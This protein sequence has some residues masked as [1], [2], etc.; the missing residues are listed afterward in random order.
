MSEDI[1]KLRQDYRGIRAPEHLATRIRAEVADQV[2]PRRS[3]LP[4]LA[5]IAVAVAAV[6]VAPLLMQQQSGDDTRVIAETRDVDT[7]HV[8][9]EE[10]HGAGVTAETKTRLRPDTTNL[11]RH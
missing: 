5:P 10:R 9:D 7:E 1:D 3:W 8:E 11:F 4:A 6:T 2:R